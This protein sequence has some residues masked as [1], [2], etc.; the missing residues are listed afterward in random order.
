MILFSSGIL[1][2]WMSEHHCDL[3][4]FGINIDVPDKRLVTCDQYGPYQN[5][6][7]CSVGM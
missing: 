5:A 4:I 3:L 2:T 7:V 1:K 6:H